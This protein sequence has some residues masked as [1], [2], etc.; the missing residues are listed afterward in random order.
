[1]PLYFVGGLSNL[2]TAT[3][4]QIVL[5]DETGRYEIAA[6]T[7]SQFANSL[8]DTLPSAF[9]TAGSDVVIAEGRTAI[10]DQPTYGNYDGSYT[11][12]GGSTALIV[13]VGAG[14]LWVSELATL[15]IDLGA[16]LPTTGDLTNEGALVVIG[17]D[18]FAAYWAP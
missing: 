15:H 2:W 5:N 4:V 10:L 6:L 11:A 1:M 8:D 14:D 13:Y 12:F 17:S 16:T 7:R 3:T 18:Q 9:A